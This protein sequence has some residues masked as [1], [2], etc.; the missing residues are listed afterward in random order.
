MWLRFAALFFLFTALS[1]ALKFDLAA[2]QPGAGKPRC[3]RNYVSKDTLVV[4]TA[5]ISGSKGDGQIVNIQVRAGWD[6]GSELHADAAQIKDTVGNEY[7]K[8]KDAVGET[9][10]AFTSHAEAAFD[11]CFEN[12]LASGMATH[13]PLPTAHHQHHPTTTTPPHHPALIH[14]LTPTRPQERTFT[15]RRARRRYWSGCARLVGD[16]GGREAEA[17]RD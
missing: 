3:I 8:S 15:R 5:T 16:P 1:H 10:M 6:W 17:G 11:V 9:R 7:G 4:V 2:F 12:T 14:P 13:C